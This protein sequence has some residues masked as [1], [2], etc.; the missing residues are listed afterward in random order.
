MLKL[1]TPS[2][3]GLVRVQMRLEYARNP[4]IFRPSGIEI[5][6]RDGDQLVWHGSVTPLEPDQTFVT[7]LSPL[8]PATFHRVFSQDPVPSIKWDTIEYRNLP[9]DALGSRA[10]RI[11]VETLHCL[12]P[13]KFAETSPAPQMAV[14]Q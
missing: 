11:E 3:C 1:S 13:Q 4:Q 6:L 10:N 7:H 5:N 14:V 9:A 8:P 2:N 12:D